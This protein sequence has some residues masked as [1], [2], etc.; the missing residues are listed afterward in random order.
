MKTFGGLALAAAVATAACSSHGTSSVLPAT[1][2]APQTTAQSTFGTH[3]VRPAAVAAAPLGWSGTATLAVTPAN[4]N[5]LGAL[6]SSQQLAVTVGLQLRNV[7][8][9]KSLVASRGRVDPTTFKSTYGPTPTQVAAVT[10]YLQ[11]QG[12]SN[13]SVEPNNLLIDATASAATV[14][15]AFNTSLHSFSVGGVS[16]FANTSPAYVPQSLSGIVVAVLGLNN[17]QMF[18]AS[19]P[20]SSRPALA[21]QVQR[22][23]QSVNQPQPTPCTWLEGQSSPVNCMRFYDPP[24][25][26]I[27]Y[28]VGNTPTADLIPVAIMTEGDVTQSISDLRLNESKF[29]LPQVPVN[30]IHS[31]LPGT[32]VSGDGEWTLDM[33]YSS[34]MAGNLSALDVYNA[35]S[36]TD[37][38]IAKMYNKWV[39]DDLTRIGNSSF[40]GCEYGPYI[41]GS[42]VLMDEILNEG[43]AQGQT[44]FVS[45]GDTGAFCPVAGVG[46]NGVPAGGALMV[47]YPASSPYVV[48]VGGTDLFSN[49][50][51][52]Y[53]GETAWEAG[54]GGI[55]QFE[56]APYWENP[57]QPI[58]T[59]PAG[60]TFRGVPDIAMDAAIETG[61]LLW[62]GAAVNGSCTPCITA[63]TSLASPLSAGVYARLLT[64]HGGLGF[65]APL[66]YSNFTSHAAGAQQTGPPPW[67][68]DG[69]FH[70]ILA[71]GNGVY[72]A[73][74]GYD[75]ASGLG[76]FDVSVMNAEIGN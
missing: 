69:G 51:G 47:N 20:M 75:F 41:D 4:A 5:D 76:S 50:D 62:G 40:G 60:L 3:S 46:E 27:T 29:N 13:V 9:L 37:S 36:F 57:A 66:F 22:R 14:S 45:S 32:D 42:M 63:G 26:W 56:Y 19:P 21:Q 65:A 34:G 70:D 7:D 71:G 30:V 6:A 61:A 43:A 55:S 58:G 35:T 31:G 67:Q 64:T 25:Y 11:S 23:T 53:A 49:A 59:T 48:A 10:T 1:Q 44:M 17:I 28:D 39:S 74:P 18:K 33:T 15:K 16:A 68:P 72:N 24:T 2:S 38:D 54:G 12:F 8:Q 52:T 73:L